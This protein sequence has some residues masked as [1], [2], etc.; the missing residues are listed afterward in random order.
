MRGGR[1]SACLRSSRWGSAGLCGDCPASPP[2]PRPVHLFGSQ[3]LSLSALLVLLVVVV[4]NKR[5]FLKRRV[6]TRVT[7]GELCLSSV[8]SLTSRRRG[9]SP[10]G[11]FLPLSWGP[12]PCPGLR[13]CA[14]GQRSSWRQP[15]HPACRRLELITSQSRPLQPVGNRIG[16]FSCAPRCSDANARNMTFRDTFVLLHPA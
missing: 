8:C 15:S 10:L 13:G 11:P 3:V 9:G 16:N 12:C 14:P 6:R 7:F 1:P 4:F 2:V 5:L